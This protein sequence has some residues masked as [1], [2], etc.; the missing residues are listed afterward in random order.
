MK[1]YKYILRSSK[2]SNWNTSKFINELKLWFKDIRSWKDFENSNWIEGWPN[3]TK[4]WLYWSIL[5]VESL[6]HFTKLLNLELN[7]N[8]IK[9]YQLFYFIPLS[10]RRLYKLEALFEYICSWG[11]TVASSTK[12]KFLSIS[13]LLFTIIDIQLQSLLKQFPFICIQ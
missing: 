4:I 13:F 7:L 6:I 12:Y 9:N 10:Y 5:M 11:I 8:Q 3:D 2:K 1:I